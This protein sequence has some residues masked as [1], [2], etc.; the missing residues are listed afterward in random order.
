[1]LV[2]IGF[3]GKLLTSYFFDYVGFVLILGFTKK[4]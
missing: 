2:N 4:L 3:D 1:M